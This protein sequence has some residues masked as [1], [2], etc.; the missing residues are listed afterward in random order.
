MIM[1]FLGGWNRWLVR[2]GTVLLV[3]GSNAADE[4]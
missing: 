4:V 2:A 1:S 3:F